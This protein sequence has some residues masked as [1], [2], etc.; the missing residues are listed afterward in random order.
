MKNA[1][2]RVRE[3][4]IKN[5]NRLGKTSRQSDTSHRTR[6]KYIK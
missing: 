1:V 3:T 6:V 5:K 2:L 4:I